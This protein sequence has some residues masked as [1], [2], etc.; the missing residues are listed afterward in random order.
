MAVGAFSLTDAWPSTALRLAVSLAIP[1]VAAAAW[2]T[3]NVPGDRSRSGEA[4]VPVPGILRLVIEL[5]VF[6]VAVFLLWFASST[7]AMI[8]GV[9]VAIHYLLSI[10]RIGWLLR[11]GRPGSDGRS[12]NGRGA[13]EDTAA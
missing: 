6:L 10:D 2:A 7:M 11:T 13:G 5:D 8:L 12:T 9:A 1:L 4:P 3:F